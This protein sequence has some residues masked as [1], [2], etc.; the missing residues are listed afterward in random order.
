MGRA[1]EGWNP[2]QAGYLE[3]AVFA[4][5]RQEESEDAR[6]FRLCMQELSHF[7]QP[8]VKTLQVLSS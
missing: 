3:Y 4:G 1:G 6:E 8:F 5:R 7:P 2:L